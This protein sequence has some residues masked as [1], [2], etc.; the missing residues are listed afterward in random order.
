MAQKG[1]SKF[2]DGWSDYFPGYLYVLWL[3]GKIRGILPDVLLHKLPSIF[4]D[5][6]TGYLIYKIAR[7][8][9]SEKRSLLLTSFYVFNPAVL[10]NS[11][12]WGQIDSLVC[13]FSLLTIF[14]LDK[15]I[16]FSAVALSVG[17]LIKPQVAFL[18]PLVLFLLIDKRKK[19]KGIV[20][21]IFLAGTIFL[22][23]FLP[24][25]SFGKNLFIFIFERLNLSLNQYPY[26]SVNAFNFWGL[27]G[28]WK[29]DN[30]IF[31]LAIVGGIVYILVFL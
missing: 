8:F 10:A 31:P 14:L 20:S 4:S 19:I 16:L 30:K 18:S 26:T 5:L 3:L 25:K 1:F 24:F 22:L 9:L 17:T 29:P 23:G 21:Y 7:K 11:T 13:L 12:L 6:L 28:F 27:F 2:Y 15:S